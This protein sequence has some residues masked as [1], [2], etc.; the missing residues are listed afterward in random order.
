MLRRT[1]VLLIAVLIV[2]TVSFVMALEDTSSSG[3][4]GYSSRERRATDPYSRVQYFGYDY[5]RP[6]TNYGS[7]GPRLTTQG[8]KG[9][10]G[11]A[12]TLDTSDFSSRG[13]DPSR[14]SN[15]DPGMKGSDRVD[16]VVNLFPAEVVNQVVAGIST[17]SKGTVRVLSQGNQYGSGSSSP[18]RSVEVYLQSRNLPPLGS[19]NYYEVWLVDTSSGYPISLGLMESGIGSTAQLRFQL[20]GELKGDAIMVTVE[21]FPDIDPRPT[22]NVVLYGEIG[23]TRKQVNMPAS[24]AMVMAR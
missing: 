7:K 16:I 14:I 19:E 6:L 21:P 24:F 5:V 15:F 22:E 8:A 17:I 3:Y 4:T 18:Y 10:S 23:Q 13:R 1:A 11:A 2:S 9:D 20:N 12:F